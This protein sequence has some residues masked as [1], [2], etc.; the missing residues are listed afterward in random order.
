MRRPS[1]RH[2]VGGRASQPEKMA[3]SS[4]ELG[5]F[6]TEMLAS[7]RNLA[8]LI[9]LTGAWVDSVSQAAASR[10]TDSR[11]A[12]F[13]KRRMG[14]SREPPPPGTSSAAA[15]G[16]ATTAKKIGIPYSKR[17]KRPVQSHSAPVC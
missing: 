12:Q 10:E 7:R 8:S 15:S 9:N 6:E 16:L 1:V 13:L 11:H 2:I 4:S 14:I 3:A 17:T 5:R